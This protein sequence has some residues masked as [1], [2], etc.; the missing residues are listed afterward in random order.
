MKR[1]NTKIPTCIVFL[2]LF[3]FTRCEKDPGP[4]EP[5]P[6]PDGAFYDVLVDLGVDFDRDGSISY[7]EAEK[8]TVLIVSGK[9][10]ADL[11]GIEV[12]KNLES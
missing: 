3:F 6:I 2:V 8:I 12:F 7:A 4:G 5:V 1:D 9:R 11:K 10:L